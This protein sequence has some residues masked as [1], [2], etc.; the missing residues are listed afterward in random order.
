MTN[1]CERGWTMALFLGIFEIVGCK[2]DPAQARVAPPSAS[3]AVTS[4]A[5]FHVAEHGTASFLID[6]PL[7]KIKG[8]SEKLR[9]NLA[10][11]PVDLTRTRGEVD[12][13]LAALAT[14][15]F[16]D[17]SK[18]S[19]QTEH[20]HNW[21]EIGNDVDAKRREENRWARFT[22]RSVDQV[23]AARLADAPEKGGERTVNIAA[24]GDL[25]LHG[26]SAPKTLKL[27]ATFQGP[28]AAPTGVHLVTAEPLRLSLKEHDIKPRD[29]AGTFLAGALEKVGQKIDDVVQVSLDF[30]AAPAKP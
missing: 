27:V 26:V 23:S 28:P 6:A 22:L 11:D 7:E 30:T 5:G 17:A 20:A 19:S 29:V 4:E 3:A 10:V 25:W 2:D 12:V 14:T 21:F 1:V 13:D 18:N 16:D 9:G 8:R 24:Q 15:T